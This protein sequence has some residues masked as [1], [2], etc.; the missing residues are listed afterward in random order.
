VPAFMIYAWRRVSATALR[1][2]SAA[3]CRPISA[4][5]LSS[6]PIA[7]IPVIRNRDREQK[8]QSGHGQIPEFIKITDHD[9]QDIAQK[10]RRKLDEI[11]E[12]TVVI[13]EQGRRVVPEKKK[14]SPSLISLLMAFLMFVTSIRMWQNKKEHET[15]KAESDRKIALL[16]IQ[17]TESLQEQEKRAL[18][19]LSSAKETL[20]HALPAIAGRLKER[21]SRG[22]EIAILEQEISAAFEGISLKDITV[23][24]VSQDSTSSGGAATSSL[25][26]T[27]DIQDS[28]PTKNDDQD[29]K[30]KAKR[31]I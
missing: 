10:V 8:S 6:D 15:H 26:P 5:F 9:V 30:P 14:I 21:A 28:D 4:R 20:L 22:K 3:Q 25:S 7:Q 1:S 24:K 13:D 17:A 2:V 27:N 11:N 18:K 12:Q 16:E 23:D 31:L 29:S 19:A